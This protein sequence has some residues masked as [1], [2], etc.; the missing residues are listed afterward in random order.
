[1]KHMKTTSLVAVALGFL[2]LGAGEAA[3]QA[4]T[5][6]VSAN[7]AVVTIEWTGLLG[8][9]GYNLQVGTGPGLANIASV[10]LPATTTKIIVTAPAGV[11]AL[12]V[13]ACAPACDVPGAIFGPFSN[14]VTV[15]VGGPGPGPGPCGQVA[16]PKISVNVSGTILAISWPPVAGAIGYQIVFSQTPGGSQLVY[17]VGA[18]QTSFSQN[19]G[20]LAGTYYVRVVAGDACSTAVSQEV[21]FTLGGAPPPGPGPA[22]PPGSGP[23]TPDPA[24]GQ[25]LPLPSYG[26]AVMAQVAAVFRGD[27][28]NACGSRT[29]LYRLVRELR[30]RDT[31]WGMNYKRGHYGDLS[32]DIVTYNPTSLPDNQASRIYLIDVVG[33]ICEGNYPVWDP[34]ATDKTWAARGDPV[35][36]TEWC[37]LWTI[38]HY[39]RA[40]FPLYPTD[41]REPQ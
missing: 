23:R 10:N 31:R 15:N 4:P 9:G 27:L 8:A 29:Y 18:G 28:A 20:G 11:Y 17:T 37:A 30:K 13:R 26:E 14:V 12:R 24:P 2:A 1:M 33:S 3:A 16:A 41:E 36:G 38:D 22:P 21:Q 5:L 35:C 7:G 6:A 32:T 40:G 25:I 39:L 19:V 34:S